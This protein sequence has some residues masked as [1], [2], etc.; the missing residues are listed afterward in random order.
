MKNDCVRQVGQTVNLKKKSVHQICQTALSQRRR[1]PPR[2]VIDAVPLFDEL[3]V[4]EVRSRADRSVSFV[5]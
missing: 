1:H 3:D 5:C 4:L 2:F